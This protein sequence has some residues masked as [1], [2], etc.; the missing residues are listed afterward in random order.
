MLYAFK[1]LFLGSSLEVLWLRLHTPNAGGMALIPAQG[2]K[3]PSAT[4]YGL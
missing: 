4:W 3:I 1:I 2:T